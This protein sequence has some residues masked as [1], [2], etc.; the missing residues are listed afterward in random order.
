MRIR[1][2]FR[3]PAL[4]VTCFVMALAF[5]RACERARVGLGN[6]VPAT[7]PLSAA[8][9]RDDLAAANEK[10]ARLEH[11]ALLAKEAKEAL[12]PGAP[13]LGA[14]RGA[15]AR[16][17]TL[18]ALR[19]SHRDASDAR[20]SFL[21]DGGTADGVVE[22]LAVVN[23]DSLVGL[24]VAATE[25]A[26]RVVRI[27]DP[28]PASIVPAAIL[29]TDAGRAQTRAPGVA[30]GTGDG[31]VVVSLLAANDAHVGDL[32]V[33]G[34]GNPL[35]PEGLVLGEVIAF[36]DDDRDG[37]YEAIVRPLRDFDTLASVVVLRDERAVAAGPRVGARK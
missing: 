10:I 33:T 6:L 34:A 20:R 4:L 36:G 7:A 2:N 5:P 32:V 29:V 30:R 16:K 22:G 12:P 19:V 9:K 21:L 17:L 25:H 27:D 35:V 3:V 24:V 31:E 18:I 8:E 37:S 15:Q 23:G 13:A 28:T 14:V 1:E 11:D 26:C